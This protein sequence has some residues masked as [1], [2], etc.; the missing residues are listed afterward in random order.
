MDV[1][2]CYSLEEDDGIPEEDS[3]S[4]SQFEDESEELERKGTLFWMNLTLIVID[5]NPCD[6]QQNN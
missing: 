2:K 5:C 1:D 3:F 4:E 6:H